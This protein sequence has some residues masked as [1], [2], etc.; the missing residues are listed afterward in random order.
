MKI[1]VAGATGAIGRRLIP[2]LLKAGHAVTGTTRSAEKAGAL[3]TLG[4]TPKV[5]DVFDA[6]TLVA[7]VAAT[8]PDVIVHQL[9]DLPQRL[10]GA[11]M[12]A[13]LDAN[14]RVRIEGTRNLM[15]AAREAGVPRVIAQSIAWIYG[16]GARPFT[17][18]APLT[19][20]AE[21][22]FKRTL[23]GV[24]ALEQTVLGDPVI[25]GLVLRY[26]RLYGPGIWASDA[27]G[28]APL[29]VDAA[30]Q[31]AYQA[32][33]RGNAGVY[34]VAEEDGYLSAAKARTELGFDPAF[35]LPS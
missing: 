21:G 2:L 6:E 35:R 33:T 14:A 17:E 34:N 13:A 5:V 18:A 3:A 22:T 28:E 15:L 24:R 4:V 27:P 20:Q 31:A 25:V 1:F 29:H 12:A 26:G 30:A 9:T 8:S 11:D 32:V 10:E 7:D 19:T 23:E 16:E